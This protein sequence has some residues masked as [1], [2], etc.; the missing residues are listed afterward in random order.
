[1]DTQSDSRG[2]TEEIGQQHFIKNLDL[3]LGCASPGRTCNN[4][5]FTFALFAVPWSPSLSLCASFTVSCGPASYCLVGHAPKLLAPCQDRARHRGSTENFPP[6]SLTSCPAQSVYSVTPQSPAQS[7]SVRSKQQKSSSVH[8]SVRPT[9]MSN[10]CHIPP[11]HIF[12][13]QVN[14]ECKR[15]R[16]Q[17]TTKK[18]QRHGKRL[19]LLAGKAHRER[20]DL[21]I[22][23]HKGGTNINK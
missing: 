1:M 12:V 2:Y 19:K 21:T 6:L 14:S 4:C 8:S 16:R 13:G 11:F 23:Q 18:P 3:D 17:K 5:L 7:F 9:S 20:K 10:A 22:Q 15:Q